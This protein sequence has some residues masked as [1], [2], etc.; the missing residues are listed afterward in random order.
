MICR[1]TGL[2]LLSLWGCIYGLSLDTALSKSRQGSS[3][4]CLPLHFQ[5]LPAF[6][7][8]KNVAVVGARDL[9]WQWEPLLRDEA[10]DE[11]QDCHSKSP[12]Q[13]VLNDV[14]SKTRLTGITWRFQILFK[15]GL[16]LLVAEQRP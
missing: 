4:R 3:A 5:N 15:V 6:R 9:K 13:S 11:S 10:L 7:D 2:I 8:D 12:V 1:F 14:E 16:R